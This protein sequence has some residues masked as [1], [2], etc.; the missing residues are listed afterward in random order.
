M[1]ACGSR[2]R[3]AGAWAG[4]RERELTGR[5][6]ELRE[7]ERSLQRRRIKHHEPFE[8]RHVRRHGSV[9]S[10][11]VGC[12]RRRTAPAGP[13]A[14]QSE[15][16][17]TVGGTVQSGKCSVSDHALVPKILEPGTHEFGPQLFYYGGEQLSQQRAEEQLGN[18][19]VALQV[20]G[21]GCG[22]SMAVGRVMCICGQSISLQGRG[23]SLEAQWCAR[24]S[25]S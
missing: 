20:L 7:R 12:W 16:A 17:G 3:R 6:E 23:P 24:S 15:A 1:A 5:L 13:G 21:R 25:G 8:A 10:G 2:A 9:R 22:R 4:S 14:T 18:Q 19:L 11:L